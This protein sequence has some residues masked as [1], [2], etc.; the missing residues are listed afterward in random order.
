[1]E[2]HQFIK[3][4]VNSEQVLD[5]SEALRVLTMVQQRRASMVVDQVAPAVL[6]ATAGFQ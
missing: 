4:E 1:M 2:F 5:A 6:V 3:Q